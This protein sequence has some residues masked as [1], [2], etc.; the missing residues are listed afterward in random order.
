M[1]APGQLRNLDQHFADNTGGVEA[2]WYVDV[3]DVLSVPDPDAA[4]ITESVVLRPNCYWYQLV[5]T[6]TT[7]GFTQPGKNDRHGSFWQP[8]LK[9]VLAKATAELAQGLE[10]LDDRRLLVI[11][12]DNNG[13]VW[14]VGQHD[15]PLKFTDK[16]DAGTTTARNN[17]DF[18]FSGETTRRARPYQGTWEVSGHGL[19][20]GVQL[21][22]G[23]GGTV[24]LR[25]AGGRLLAIVPAGKSIVLKSGIKLGYAI[26]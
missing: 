3:T 19:E 16:Y 2:L 25:T 1:L 6:R 14:L 8:S 11:Y 13:L 26:V 15:E 12:R 7:L 22:T 23:A 20:S 10:A 24:E 18:T 4:L 9:G 5:A 17:Y 21:G